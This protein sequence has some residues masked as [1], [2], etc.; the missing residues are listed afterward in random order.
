MVLKKVKLILKRVFASIIL[1][2]LIN[3]WRLGEVGEGECKSAKSQQFFTGIYFNLSLLL[4]VLNYIRGKL[5]F[6]R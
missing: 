3:Q 2:F 6:A 5:K 1:S 4:E